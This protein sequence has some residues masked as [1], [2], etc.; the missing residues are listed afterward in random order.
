MHVDFQVRVG[1]DGRLEGEGA[2]GAAGLNRV[3]GQGGRQGRLGG[4]RLT[5]QH[6]AVGDRH[7]PEG[8]RRRRLLLDLAQ[9]R[10]R[11][12]RCARLDPLRALSQKASHSP[13]VFSI[14]LPPPSSVTVS[15]L[16]RGELNQTW[17]EPCL[18]GIAMSRA[19]GVNW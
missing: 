11:V 16:S 17:L 13:V 1:V 9:P 4:T 12:R 14:T 2:R 7:Q 3:A 15:I 8:A 5:V 18:A 19:L 10:R 6:V